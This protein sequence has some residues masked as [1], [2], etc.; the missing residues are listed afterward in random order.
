M[1]GVV[2]WWAS[3]FFIDRSRDVGIFMN[4][5][6]KLLLSIAIHV[7]YSFYIAYFAQNIKVNSKDA[8][9]D[10]DSDVKAVRK[11]VSKLN[12]HGAGN[13]PFPAVSKP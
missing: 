11:P 12:L 10:S 13:Y 8:S 1:V 5:T 6:I 2:I 7:S 4:N 3:H 9:S